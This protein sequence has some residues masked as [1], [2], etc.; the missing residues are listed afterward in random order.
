M[1]SVALLHGMR[2][3]S[4]MWWHLGSGRL[5]IDSTVHLTRLKKGLPGPAMLTGAQVGQYREDAPVG[6]VA[7][8]DIELA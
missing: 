8:R 4:P 1:G 2:K 7:V 3:L 6:V 5:L